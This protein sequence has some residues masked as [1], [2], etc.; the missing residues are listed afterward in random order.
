MKAFELLEL[1]S[2]KVAE[3]RGLL[4]GADLEKRDLTADEAAKFDAM[5][6]D[7]AKLEAQEQ[8]AAFLESVERAKPVDKQFLAVEQRVTVLDAIRAQVG[9]RAVG[10][11]LAEFNQET[12]LRTGRKAQGVFVPLQAFE[13]RAA[14]TTTTAAGIV[15]EDF[16][17]S[18]YI[19]PL[20]KSL[21]ARGLGIRTM[22]GLRGDVVIPKY[23]S[24]MTADWVNEDEA[25]SASGMKFETVTMKPKH[26]GAL[27]ELSRQLIQQSSPDINALVTDDLSFILADAIDRAIL[28][29]DGVKAPLGILNTPDIQTASLAN[30]SYAEVLKL[31]ELLDLANVSNAKFLTNPSVMRVLRSVEKSQGTGLYLA[32][33][34]SIGDVES[35]VSN[36]LSGGKLLLGDFSQFILGIW[37]EVDILVNPYAESAYSKG[38]VLVRA[39]MTAGSVVRHPEAFVLVDDVPV[40]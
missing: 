2:A 18:E 6:A 1:K 39:M 35:V 31:F 34:A 13:M 30:P 12:E 10:G 22:T 15:P 36:Q 14:Q 29:G 4:D 5:K 24:G 16:Y 21:V 37:S 3:M 25:L 38:N 7:I 19:G 28:L 17:A 32:G 33:G 40:A 9:G 8:R 26:V 27:T 23:K 20:R 11:A